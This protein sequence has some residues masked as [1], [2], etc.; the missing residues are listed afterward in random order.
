MYIVH[1][2]VVLMYIHDGMLGN[3]ELLHMYVC[4]LVSIIM[5]IL[6]RARQKS[7]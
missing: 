2:Y 1:K 6:L 3:V 5:Y 4:I 7:W